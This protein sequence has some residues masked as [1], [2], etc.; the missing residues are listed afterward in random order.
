MPRDADATAVQA[1]KVVAVV[2]ELVAVAAVLLN[3]STVVDILH[4]LPL[5]G[6]IIDIPLLGWIVGFGLVVGAMTF[7]SMIVAGMVFAVVRRIVRSEGSPEVAPLPRTEAGEHGAKAESLMAP[8]ASARPPVR[9]ASN[10]PSA[11]EAAVPTYQLRLRV[12][13]W[14]DL[15]PTSVRTYDTTSLP[16]GTG[17]VHR[18]LTPTGY[19]VVRTR[20]AGADY[21]FTVELVDPAAGA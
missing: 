7:V 12:A 18:Y 2:F 11:A 19:A 4:A 17:L 5:V 16:R 13:S 10:Q 20:P 15:E 1:T 21:T 14:L 6:W 9:S 3:L 8:S